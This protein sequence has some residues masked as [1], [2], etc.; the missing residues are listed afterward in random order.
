MKKTTSFLLALCLVIGLA[1]PNVQAA[2]P[3]PTSAQQ[4]VSAL[5]IITGDETGNLNLSS[6]VTRAEFAK[7]MIAAS[8]YKDTISSSSKSSP[9][10]DVK[11]THWAASYVQAAVS[12]GWLTGYTDG[13]YKPDN[14]V[15]LEEAV[16]ALLKMLGFA[17]SDFVGAFPEA[18]LAKYSALG[19]NENVIKTKGQVLSR[20]DCMYL[21]YNLMS[22]KN[23]NG[24]YYATTL[25]YTVN[26]SGELN[27]SSLV[28]NNMKGPFIVSGSSWSSSLPF[29]AGSA[30]VYKNGSASTISAVSNYD[31]Y[32]YNKSMMTVWVYRNHVSGVYTAATPSTSA[33]SS[34]TVAGKTYNVS[35]S[36]A[37]YAL[38]DLGSFSIGDTVT[39]L[40]GMNGEVVGVAY[41]NDIS[42]TKYGFVISTNTKTYT[43]ST[44][45]SYSSNVITVA[46]TDGGSY[47]YECSPGYKK[48]N[49]VQ[50]SVS[51]GK[52]VVT[53]LGELSLSGTVNSTAT[54]L[55]SYAFSD[56]VEIMD[57]T[58]N[59]SYLKVY[60]SRLAGLALSSANVRYYVLDASGKISHLILN[61]ATGDMYKYGILT[62]SS[63][64][65]DSMNVSSSY[66]YIIDGT[67]GSYVSNSFAFGVSTEPVQMEF[68]ENTII[69]M[70][71]LSRI[72]I[73]YLN[74]SYAQSNGV[75]YLLADNVSVYINKNGSYYYSSISALSDTSKYSIYGYYDKAQSN[76][77]RIRIIIANEN[78]T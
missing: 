32:Y 33:P 8:I 67:H 41:S 10:K 66:N 51:G 55:G 38:S 49:L 15:K 46:C 7:M 36:S 63:E 6:T 68:S 50:I 48:G 59:G 23:K 9:F 2:A 27:Y 60:P 58:F 35:S 3:D 12:A 13:T 61:D 31:V 47:E 75:Q 20:Q 19:L 26:S 18:Q 65:N 73:S 54:S 22:T 30:K 37:S 72:S 5:G 52:T 34:V 43:G 64:T 53:S 25:G 4:I 78:W 42:S 74:S 39:L 24:S 14:N 71:N 28:M 11:Y 29:A 62:S 40:L 21:F 45:T 17:S 76:G 69:K 1:M 56:N 16:S 70:K 77:G 57:S 44:G